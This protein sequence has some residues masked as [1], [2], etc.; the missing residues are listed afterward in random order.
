MMPHN[1]LDHPG[2]RSS[3]PVKYTSLKKA[4]ELLASI[5][6]WLLLF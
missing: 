2:R 5:Y 3:L 6:G 1:S 4:R